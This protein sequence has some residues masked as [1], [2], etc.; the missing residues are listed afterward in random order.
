MMNMA[1]TTRKAFKEQVQEHILYIMS[2]EET[3]DVKEQL[4]NV[5]DGFNNWYDAYE[6]K[7]NPNRWAA[8]ADW[9]MGLPSEISVEYRH[10]AI[11]ALLQQ[12]FENCGEEYKE[13]EGNEEQTFY[14]SLI[15]REFL[16]LCRKYGIN[17]Y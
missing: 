6:K 17:A 3:N 4:Q 10:Y 8:M 5:V 2:D 16:V 9:F 14:N 11:S 12:W 1:V 15:I 13:R 7:Q